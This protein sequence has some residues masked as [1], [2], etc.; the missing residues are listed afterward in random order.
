MGNEVRY[1]VRYRT[2]PYSSDIFWSH[3]CHKRCH[4]INEGVFIRT[5]KLYS[6]TYVSMYVVSDNNH[7]DI[8]FQLVIFFYLIN[9]LS[10]DPTYVQKL[11]V[12]M[13][14]DYDLKSSKCTFPKKIKNVSICSTYNNYIWTKLSVTLKKKKHRDMY[15]P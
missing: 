4:E 10:Y 15:V 12:S 9:F 2:V 6:D 1:Q 11:Y 8:V 5:Y 14:W 13:F 7:F 3:W